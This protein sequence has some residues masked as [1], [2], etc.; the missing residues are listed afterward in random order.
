MPTK[1]IF[2]CKNIQYNKIKHHQMTTYHK[3][4]VNTNNNTP[5][6]CHIKGVSI[7]K[8]QSGTA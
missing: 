6:P 5:S 1:V 2:L 4:K 3:T 8:I 7:I